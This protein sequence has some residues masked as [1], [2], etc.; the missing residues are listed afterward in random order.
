MKSIFQII[1]ILFFIFILNGVIAEDEP[2]TPTE[3]MSV[4]K[5]S[6]YILSPDGKYLI[7]GVKNGIP[8]QE[9]HILIFVI[10]I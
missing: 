2:F 8:I 9:N 3:M 5:F 6:A 1:K 7:M 10:K 4:E